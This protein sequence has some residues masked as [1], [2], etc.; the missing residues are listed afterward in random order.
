MSAGVHIYEYAPGFVHSKVF[1]A[2]DTRAVVGTL[3]LDY[4]SLYLNFECGAYLYKVPAIADILRDFEDTFPQCRPVTAET[5][6]RQKLSTRLGAA[7][8]KLAAPL[9]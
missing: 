5:V 2:D 7:I 1:L 3:N 6:A 9:M 4:R 8:L